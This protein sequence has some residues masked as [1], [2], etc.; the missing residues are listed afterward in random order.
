MNDKWV[1]VTLV[2]GRVA[3]VN[4]SHIQ[5]LA[6]GVRHTK[7]GRVTETYVQFNGASFLTVVDSMDELVG[8][9]A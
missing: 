8:R 3:W 2:N 7:E 1:K 4:A 9:L 5:H 6:D